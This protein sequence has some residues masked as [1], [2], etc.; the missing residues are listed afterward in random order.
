MSDNFFNNPIV[1]WDGQGKSTSDEDTVNTMGG[2]DSLPTDEQ[3]AATDTSD[4]ASYLSR[5][6]P[7]ITFDQFTGGLDQIAQLFPGVQVKPNYQPGL[8]DIT[9]TRGYYGPQQDVTPS[10]YGTESAG[11]LF[12]SPQRYQLPVYAETTAS[13]SSSVSSEFDSETSQVMRDLF[14]PFLTYTST[15]PS[16]TV[17][18]DTDTDTDTDSDKD[19]DSD[20]D[21]DTDTDIGND[22]I[23]G[24][25]TVDTIIGGNKNDTIVLDDTLEGGN[26][27][28][29]I[30]IDDTVDGG[31]NNDTIVID[32]TLEGSDGN[33][34][35]IGGNQ[36]DTVI[37]GN[38]N[39]TLTGGLTDD[40]LFINKVYQD[41]FERD[42]DTEGRDYWESQLQ[43]G[44][45]R[46]QVIRDI[47]S[48]AQGTDIGALQDENLGQYIEDYEASQVPTSNKTTL[49][50][51]YNENFGRNADD[52]G[53]IYWS[54]QL[55]SGKTVDQVRQDILNA[56]SESDRAFMRTRSLEGYTADLNRDV[57]NQ[58]S[59]IT[60]TQNEIN[61]LRDQAYQE[62][63]NSYYVTS[64]GEGSEISGY[65][66]TDPY[67]TSVGEQLREKETQLNNE[68]RDLRNTTTKLND[69]EK[70]F[71]VESYVA[72]NP[73]AA[74]SNLDPFTH[75]LIYGRDANQP[76]NFVMD[77]NAYYLE[78]NPDVASTGLNP[79]EHYLLKG[80]TEGRSD[81][82]GT[83]EQEYLRAYPDVAAAIREGR[84][85]SAED[86]YKR[87]GAA[88]GRTAGYGQVDNALKAAT[89]EYI[90]E[91]KTQLRQPGIAGPPPLSTIRDN[92][93]ARVAESS[94][95][96][97]NAISKT[98][99]AVE[100]VSDIYKTASNAALLSSTSESFLRAAGFA[101]KDNAI[102]ALTR[103]GYD[104]VLAA[105]LVDSA[106]VVPDAAQA[107]IGVSRFA[108][109]DA[110]AEDLLESV[111]ASSE[112][113]SALD[114]GTMADV[115][116]A[117]EGLQ[118]FTSAGKAFASEAADAVGTY[119]GVE[120]LSGM[121]D[122]ALS[123]GVPFVGLLMDAFSADDYG[124][125]AQSAADT[126]ATAAI[127]QAGAY[128][129]ASLGI[130][131]AGP[132]IAAAFAL[133]AVLAE[134]LGYDSFIQ[135][136]ISWVS[137][138]IDNFLNWAGENIGDIFSGI[139]DF[140]ENLAQGGLVQF[141][142]GGLVD[143]PDEVAYYD[144]NVM[145]QGV[146]PDI[147]QYAQGGVI[148]LLG[149]GK[150]ARGPGGGLDDL[151][152]T[153]I[154]GKRAAALS[155]GEFVIPAD[156]VSMMGDGSSNAGAKR[157]YDMVRQV[158]QTKTGTT[159][160][161]GPL[162]TGK[163][164]ERVMR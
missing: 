4:F 140:F 15:T 50:T 46:E 44:K 119:L 54:K 62:I 18:V 79:Y 71:A 80:F 13:S 121:L 88:E 73:D 35:I 14:M 57:Q 98:A 6:I 125:F 150:I 151:I 161:A 137:G 164:L 32:D 114:T 95:G 49:D 68:L 159:K 48:G 134:A 31:N 93:V 17:V 109:N 76:N 111:S 160:Q 110:M 25:N 47:V 146:L 135:D 8:T 105:D 38:D 148:P 102:E 139:G 107:I 163:I 40:E 72:R 132:F 117:L 33:D 61:A 83:P 19:T 63:D 74:A 55:E 43:S 45:T 142:E 53:L 143:I 69:A 67:K 56:A 112:I 85:T 24:G 66:I 130:P 82:F 60:N 97:L 41:L 92:F 101:S 120:G 7:N 162:P 37:G 51:I 153:S 10:Q 9:F 59:T 138:P 128:A 156:V 75:F 122:G 58:T 11:H 34:T 127:T 126:L 141:Q 154:D 70:N 147:E 158:R 42:A 2:L 84:F 100:G 21:T 129:L 94:P 23:D 108:G 157:L 149:G 123:S 36:N 27:N 78:K 20:T 81:V 65:S 12:W 131:G 103:A 106:G 115:A 99:T 87:V 77:A 116:S 113:M 1:M 96:L 133:D 144:Y 104:P 30:V 152:P 29:S 3:P 86:H 118:S 52:G 89:N 5:A 124:D 26:K 22:T 136:A 16:S 64:G 90:E 28:D 145:G 155:D 39:D 91:L